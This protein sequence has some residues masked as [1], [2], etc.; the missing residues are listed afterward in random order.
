MWLENTHLCTKINDNEKMFSELAM[1][2]N[3][4]IKNKCFNHKKIHKGSWKI[5]GS[6]QT[7]KIDHVLVS[8]K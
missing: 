3:C 4:I 8:R 6:E 2:N 1:A 7:N 5:S